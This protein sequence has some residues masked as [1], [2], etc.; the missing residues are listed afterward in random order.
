MGFEE[1]E[2]IQPQGG[3]GDAQNAAQ[4]LAGFELHEEQ[5]AVG[6]VAG[7]FLEGAEEVDGR[8][9]LAEAEGLDGGGGVGGG[10]CGI[11]ELVDGGVGEVGLLRV[12]G[13]VGVVGR[14][15]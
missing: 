2:D 10:G 15:A 12:V 6:F 14:G 11:A 8:V 9:E 1:F 7:E 13:V 5:D 3:F 4:D